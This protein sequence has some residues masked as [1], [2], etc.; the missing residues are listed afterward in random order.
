MSV[1]GERLFIIP[2]NFVQIMPKEPVLCLRKSQRIAKVV[3][4]SI[5]DVAISLSNSRGAGDKLF[6]LKRLVP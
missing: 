6:E 5:R 4:A 2:S 1:G 3:P